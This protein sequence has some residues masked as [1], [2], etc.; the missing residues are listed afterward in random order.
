MVRSL[1]EEDMDDYLSRFDHIY[2][3]I[4]SMDERNAGEI[5][6]SLLRGLDFHTTEFLRRQAPFLQTGQFQATDSEAVH[7]DVYLDEEIMLQ[8]LDGLL[9]TYVAWPNQ[10]RILRFYTDK[11]LTMEPRGA[12]LEVGPG[13]GYL[14]L[15]QLLACPDAMLTAYDVSPHSVDY[16]RRILVSGG[17]EP[18]RFRIKCEDFMDV[19]PLPSGTIRRVILA[20]VLEHVESPGRVLRKAVD[21]AAAGSIVFV[22]TCIN[23]EAVDHIYLFTSTDEIRDLL[24]DCRL[25]VEHELVLPLNIGRSGEMFCANY[26]AICRV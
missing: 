12:V 24:R 22:T 9:M 17:V 16:C 1:S 13:H 6:A 7:R 19:E 14:S 10:Y 23:I 8:Y 15:L 5:D 20:E 3:L 2:S 11:F 21:C 4:Q 26:A 25:S 18:G